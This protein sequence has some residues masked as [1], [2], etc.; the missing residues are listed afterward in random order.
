MTVMS[1]R[2]VGL[3]FEIH[4]PS[5]SSSNGSLQKGVFGRG[6][7]F[8]STNCL[9]WWQHRASFLISVGITLAA[10][11]IY[12]L[13]GSATPLFSFRTAEYDLADTRFKSAAAGS[14]TSGSAL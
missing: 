12:F 4:F 6:R 9:P 11:V 14:Y 10:L 13:L 8:T 5:S 1:S 2:F 3:F 7:L